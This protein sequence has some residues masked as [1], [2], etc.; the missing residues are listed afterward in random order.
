MDG[1]N[2]GTGIDGNDDFFAISGPLDLPG[3]A[4]HFVEENEGPHVLGSVEVEAARD[5]V[6]TAGKRNIVNSEFCKLLY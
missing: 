1:L 2:V 5:G 6:C 3:A 4:I